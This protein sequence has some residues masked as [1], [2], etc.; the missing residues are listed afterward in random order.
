MRWNKGLIW[1]VKIE[2]LWRWEKRYEESNCETNWKNESEGEDGEKVERIKRGALPYITTSSFPPPTIM[3]LQMTSWF[4]Y[5][6]FDINILKWWSSI[7]EFR[8]NRNTFIIWQ[9]IEIYK[10]VLA[11]CEVIFSEIWWIW[12]MS[13]MKWFFL[14]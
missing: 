7:C 9:H 5:F 14:V 1:I 6:N 11:I 4:S 13:P 10:N 2:N 8:Q 3:N 12:A